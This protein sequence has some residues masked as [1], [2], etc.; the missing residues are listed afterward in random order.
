MEGAAE[1]CQ[2]K[3]DMDMAEKPKQ[4]QPAAKGLKFDKDQPSERPGQRHTT[5]QAESQ[6]P[7]RFTEV[8]REPAPVERS[9]DDG[10]RDTERSERPFEKRRDEKR[11][12][13]ATMPPGEGQD[14]KRNTM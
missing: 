6:V 11:H 9:G 5:G 10:V 12:T 13:E 4:Q 2:F 8:G 7:P 1:T 14:P 3:G